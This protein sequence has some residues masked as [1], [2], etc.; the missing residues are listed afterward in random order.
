[1]C[2]NVSVVGS[3]VVVGVLVVVPRLGCLLMF[4][5]RIQPVIVAMKKKISKVRN[6][7]AGFQALLGDRSW[8][9][10]V[11]DLIGELRVFPVVVLV[12]REV[13]ELFLSFLVVNFGDPQTSNLK[14]CDSCLQWARCPC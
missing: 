5:I 8:I 6:V 14:I 7:L 12:A 4:W 2:W 10:K 11:V 3:P 9:L 13:F 1:M